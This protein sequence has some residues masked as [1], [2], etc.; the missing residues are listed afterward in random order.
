MSATSVGE[1]WLKDWTIRL[2]EAETVA[3][4]R[5][6]HDWL[7]STW[8]RNGA[9]IA[10]ELNRLFKV[11]DI[12][13]DLP[14]LF[15][16]QLE[17]AGVVFININPGWH[18]ELNKKENAIVSRSKQHSWE[19]CRE[20]FTR[21]PADIK[22]N[23]W[24][25]QA[26]GIG[27]RILCGD[28]SGIPAQKKREWANTNIAGWELAPFHSSGA[29]FLK[30]LNEKPQGALL[31]GAMQA[32]FRLASALP[33]KIIVVACKDGAAMANEL[34]AARGWRK[35]RVPGTVLPPRTAA[36]QIRNRLLLSVPQQLV[37]RFSSVP[38]D[39]ICAPIRDLYAQVGDAGNGKPDDSKHHDYEH[40]T[41]PFHSIVSANGQTTIPVQV[42]EAL[43]IKPGNRLEYTIKRDCVAIRVHP[44][45][46]SVKGAIASDKGN[47]MTFAKIREEATKEWLREHRK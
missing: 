7:W 39:G 22:P 6:V 41:R 28:P 27:Y 8:S 36:Y 11:T 10:A 25:D 4:V 18:E 16:G 46:K 38:R 1:R 23:H 44:G 45:I 2:S 20:L 37:S 43:R 3:N 24:W 14:N 35:L 40:L 9:K 34:A 19:F 26:I 17:K 47:G 32:S 30:C 29:G 33:A 5:S 15:A 13:S 31:R 12:K 21:Y 42:R